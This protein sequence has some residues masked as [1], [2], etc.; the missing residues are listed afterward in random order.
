MLPESRPAQFLVLN[1]TGLGRVAEVAPSL[2]EKALVCAPLVSSHLKEHGDQVP[3]PFHYSEKYIN[4][5]ETPKNLLYIGTA[6]ILAKLDS[7]NVK[8]VVFAS[9]H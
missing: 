9:P 7:Q 8:A 4:D 1:C 5:S 6:K 2:I 3:A